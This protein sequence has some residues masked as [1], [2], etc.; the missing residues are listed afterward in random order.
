MKGYT[1]QRL[2]PFYFFEQ[3]SSL[4]VVDPGFLEKGGGAIDADS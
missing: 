3:W 2:T 1:E 4:S